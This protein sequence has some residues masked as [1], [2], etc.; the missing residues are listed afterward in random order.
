MVNQN[1]WNGSHHQGNVS[2]LFQTMKS[3][4]LEPKNDDS[5]CAELSLLGRFQLEEHR[6]HV[7]AQ[8]EEDALPEA[9]DAAVAPD[10]HDA[11]RAETQST[12]TWPAGSSRNSVSASG[13]TTSSSTARIGRPSC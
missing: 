8:A 10:Q 9:Q 6:H 7:A 5:A 1:E 2:T 4:R 3:G 11:H 12:D 13:N